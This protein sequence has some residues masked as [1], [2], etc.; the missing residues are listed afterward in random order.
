[1]VKFNKLRNS[2]L[3]DGC[4]KWSICS[5]FFRNWTCVSVVSFVLMV[6]DRTSHTFLADESFPAWDTS[7]RFFN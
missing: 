2:F 1:M 5:V 6:L 7:I 4:F 3:N